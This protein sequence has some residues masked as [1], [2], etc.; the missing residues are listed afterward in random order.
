M[1]ISLFFHEN[2]NY[3]LIFGF[4]FIS[5]QPSFFINNGNYDTGVSST[6]FL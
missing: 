6:E 3:I 1:Y 4:Y 5:L 2:M